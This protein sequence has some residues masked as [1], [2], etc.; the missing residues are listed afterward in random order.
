MR[1]DW[2]IKDSVHQ[3]MYTITRLHNNGLTMQDVVELMVDD[4]TQTENVNL[5]ALGD[6]A[7]HIEFTLQ[8][9][10]LDWEEDCE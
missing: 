8:D 6:L 1:N 2:L 4:P 5:E 10:K 9:R 3:F 7:N